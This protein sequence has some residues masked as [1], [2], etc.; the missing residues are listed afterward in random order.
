MSA[1]G[2]KR[3]TAR[4]KLIRLLDSLCNDVDELLECSLRHHGATID[5]ALKG[6]FGDMKLGGQCLRTPQ[7][8]NSLTQ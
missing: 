8:F 1:F 4:V 7:A 6:A 2:Q 5:P 3:T